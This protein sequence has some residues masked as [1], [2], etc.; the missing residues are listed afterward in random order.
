[1]LSNSNDYFGEDAFS[2]QKWGKTGL[3]TVKDVLLQ[4]GYF[5]AFIE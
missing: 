2:R 3:L 4:K 5:E 1:M